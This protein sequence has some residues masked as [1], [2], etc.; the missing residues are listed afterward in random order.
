MGD[1]RLEI[2][3]KAIRR[4]TPQPHQES[5]VVY[6]TDDYPHRLRLKWRGQSG[7]NLTVHETPGNHE[8]VL[9]EPNVGFWARKLKSC[10]DAR[11]IRQSDD[12]DGQIPLGEFENQGEERNFWESVG[13]GPL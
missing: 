10:L 13:A 9:E 12:M 8:S 5:L 4:Y 11:L 3:L 2:Y 1:Q 7:G 6:V